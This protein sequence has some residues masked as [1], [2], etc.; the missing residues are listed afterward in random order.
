MSVQSRLRVGIVVVVLGGCVACSGHPSAAPPSPSVTTSADASSTDATE[1]AADGEEGAS[2]APSARDD[3]GP[4]LEAARSLDADLRSV[5][6]LVSS[7]V[8]ESDVVV[9][10]STAD[11]VRGLDLAAVASTIPAGLPEDL[12]Q[13]V[14]AVY[15]DL[16]SRTW[17]MTGFQTAGTY[18]RTPGADDDSEGDAM[19]ECLTNGSAAARQL[20]GDVA[21]VET[22]AA[23]AEPVEDVA[24]TSSRAATLAA[25]IAEVNL[26]NSGC[27]GC[28]GYVPTALSPVVW[29]DASEVSITRTGLVDGVAFTAT[30][31]PAAGWAVE[32]NAC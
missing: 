5:A 9:S 21:A 6:L 18:A 26:R 28:G 31:D 20:E 2:A 14:L 4:F 17:A 13:P 12:L 11:A 8:T 24:P 30:Y 32:I 10:E 15:S 7:S 3:L 16:V 22:A 19:V 27:A 1:P 23:G 29:D 25:R